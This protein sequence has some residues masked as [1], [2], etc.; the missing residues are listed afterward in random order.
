MEPHPPPLRPG[1]LGAAGG[2]GRGVQPLFPGPVGLGGD[3][4]GRQPGTLPLECPAGAAAV[5]PAV[6]GNRAGLAG[7][8]GG[9]G[10]AVP[11]HRG[12]LFQ[13][14]LPQRAHAVGGPVPHPGGPGHVRPVPCGPHPPD[15]RVDCG[16]RGLHGAAVLPGEGA[17][18]GGAPA[19]HP[20]GG[21][22]GEGGSWRYRNG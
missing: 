10:A 1:H 7:L 5:G 17:A 8:P 13:A 21:G 20:G 6:A 11:P 19:H 16:H 4:L 18:Q 3:Q 14:P 2:G 9:G 15:D 22:G 12:K